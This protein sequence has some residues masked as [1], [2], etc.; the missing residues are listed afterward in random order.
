MCVFW[1]TGFF[2]SC[3]AKI[4]DFKLRHVNLLVDKIPTTNIYIIKLQTFFMD[5]FFKWSGQLTLSDKSGTYKVVD[6]CPEF[7]HTFSV[8]HDISCVSSAHWY[9]NISYRIFRIRIR[10]F[11]PDHAHGSAF[12]HLQT[13]SLHSRSKIMSKKQRSN[14]LPRNDANGLWHM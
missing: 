4:C 5:I 1:L 13:D 9:G 14:K 7:Y 6:L 8:L 10:N 11:R 12:E 3:T 2:F